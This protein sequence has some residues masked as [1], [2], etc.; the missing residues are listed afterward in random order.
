MCDLITV[1][2]TAARQL[3]PSISRPSILHG[4]SRR[5]DVGQSCHPPN[6]VCDLGTLRASLHALWCRRRQLRQLGSAQ[7]SVRLTIRNALSNLTPAGGTTPPALWSKTLS[8]ESNYS[9]MLAAGGMQ[10]ISMTYLNATMF[11]RQVIR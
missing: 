11:V 2:H 8:P 4:A 3:I 6:F 7:Q 5:D 10:G 9:S 1:A